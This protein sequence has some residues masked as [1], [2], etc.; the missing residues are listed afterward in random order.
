[1]NRLMLDRPV[2]V[3]GKYDKIRLSSLVG[4][5]IFTTD[6][7]GIF[8]E[9][10]KREML[11]RIAEKRGLIVLTD[12]DGG[13]LVI[14]NFLRST[15]P[16]GKVVHLYIPQVPGKEKRKTRPSREGLL[17]VEGTSTEL[18]FRLLSP[19]SVGAESG[20]SHGGAPGGESEASP[21]G[22]QKIAQKVASGDAAGTPRKITRQD[23]YTDGLLGGEGSSARRAAL[24]RA[25][26]LPVNLGTSAFL[27]ALNL[28]SD[29]EEYRAFLEQDG[30]GGSGGV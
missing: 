28:L 9:E 22:G 24:C 19:F 23:L 17:G 21:G 7:F 4:S 29:Y 26:G 8:R 27:E 25:F 11:R 12:S 1:M 15:L 30:P 10:E 5:E 6:G 14:R 16:K 13:G 18:L 20:N 3:E 2:V